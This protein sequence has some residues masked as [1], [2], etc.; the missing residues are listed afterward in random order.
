MKL[1]VVGLGLIGGSFYK[2]SLAAGHSVVGLHHGETAGLA[3]AELVLVCLPPEAI[4][5]WIRAHAGDFRDGATVVDI[6]GVKRPVMDGVAAIPK[7][8]WRFVG[9]HPMAGREVSGYENSTADL[10]RGASMILTPPDGVPTDVLDGLRDYFASVGFHE[11]VVTTPAHHDEMIAFTS[12][13][14]H[15]IA[16]T[17]ARDPRVRD[18]VGFSAGSYANMTR[19]ATQDAA[20][21]RALYSENRTALVGVLDDF[22]ARLQDFR[23]AVAADDAPEVERLIR[24]GAAAKRQELL[25]RQR[26]DDHICHSTKMRYG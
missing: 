13:L 10:F 20:V 25:D 18:A 22:L 19:I 1:A 11:T 17:Y 8:G 7:A 3:S 15:V 24:E 12:Q 26:G 23:N 5:P 9:G 16:T 4:V 21:W 2:A 6:C 14:C